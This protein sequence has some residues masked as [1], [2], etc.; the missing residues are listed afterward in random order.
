[1]VMEESKLS[2]EAAKALL[3]THRSVRAAL[4]AHQGQD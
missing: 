2:Y 4:E 1:M 3:L